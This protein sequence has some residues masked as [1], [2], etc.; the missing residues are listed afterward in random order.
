MAFR[1]YYM[2][3]VVR[4][5]GDEYWRRRRVLREKLHEH[6]VFF[7][8]KPDNAAAVP[9]EDTADATGCILPTAAIR[10]GDFNTFGRVHDGLLSS[11]SSVS[12]SRL[13]ALCLC[14]H[15]NCRG[16]Q[17]VPQELSGIPKRMWM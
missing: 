12:I 5:R 1:A 10:A 6:R 3:I 17:I 7:A 11:E 15:I 4:L 8:F 13:P 2:F 9:A 14:F 16:F